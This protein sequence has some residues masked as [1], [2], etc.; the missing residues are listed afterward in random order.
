[1]ILLFYKMHLLGNDFVIVN[2]VTNN[3]LL[4]AEKIKLISNRHFGVGCDQLL[5]LQPPSDENHD[6]D[7]FIYNSDGSESGQ[8][9]NGTLCISKLISLEKL[10]Q[11]KNIK[12]KTKTTT[13]HIQ[14]DTVNLGKYNIEDKFSIILDDMLLDAYKISLGNPHII[15]FLDNTNYNIT[16]NLINFIDKELI[17]NNNISFVRHDDNNINIRTYERGVGLTFACGSAS[18]AASIACFDKYELSTNK[19]EVFFK[20]GSVCTEVDQVNNTVFLSGDP[21]CVFNGRMIL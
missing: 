16:D 21:K 6:F 20:Y 8:C 7:Y 17:K 1:M 19:F 5:V 11:S 13:V 14:N 10:H 3:F 9:G 15:I 4:D 18:C 2:N 12:L